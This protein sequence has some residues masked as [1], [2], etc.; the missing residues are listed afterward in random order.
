MICG[1]HIGLQ[2]AAPQW[3]SA[4]EIKG[5][6]KSRGV[7]SIPYHYGC[8]FGRRVGSFEINGSA[9]ARGYQTLRDNA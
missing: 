1:A 2:L 6:S 4:V 9:H 3:P 7:M 5:C 8:S